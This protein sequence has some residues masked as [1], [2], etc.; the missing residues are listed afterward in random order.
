MDIGNQDLI[1]HVYNA[2]TQ[3]FRAKTGG[4]ADVASGSVSAQTSSFSLYAVLAVDPWVTSTTPSP[5]S[6]TTSV[7][8]RP[9][10][11]RPGGTTGSQ[12]STAV[13]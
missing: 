2:T 3:S 7:A 6:A 1:V 11:P 5:A 12:A 10:T 8:N 9:A 13:P 4:G